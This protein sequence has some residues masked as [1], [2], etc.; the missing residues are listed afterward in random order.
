MTA[1]TTAVNRIR[2]LVGLGLTPSEA[3]QK[4]LGKPLAQ[5]AE[6]RGHRGNEV[7]M[8][9]NAYPGRTYT[10]IRDDL[11]EE[12]GITRTEVDALIDGPAPAAEAA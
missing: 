8:C 11:A 7:S 4:A 10:A 1:P 2:A 6:E 9:L 12:L 5:F 3:F